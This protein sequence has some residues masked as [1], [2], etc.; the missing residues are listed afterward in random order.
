MYLDALNYPKESFKVTL[1]A[2]TANIVLDIL[3]IPIY[4]I[5]GAA[6]ATLVSMILN[7]FLAK[8]ALSRVMK[9]RVEINS[10]MNILKASAAMSIIVG[11]YR[12]IVPLSN[13]SL[14][15]FAV[16][17]GGAVFCILMFKIDRKMYDDMKSMI[18][19][20]NLPWPNWL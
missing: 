10:L 5:I 18:L 15:L 4:G 20:M 19:Q 11:M 7:V 9:I 13:V 3:F 6:V 14:S 2:A 8:F 1:I 17:L 12:F 16:F